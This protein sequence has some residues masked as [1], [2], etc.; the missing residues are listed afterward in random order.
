M[1]LFR[2][3]KRKM[4]NRNYYIARKRLHFV[5]GNF[6]DPDESVFIIALA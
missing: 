3:N 6:D 2:V 5:L 4:R 1:D